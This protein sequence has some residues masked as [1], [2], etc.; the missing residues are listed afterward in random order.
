M[1]N[2]LILLRRSRMSN[3]G[4]IARGKHKT[5]GGCLHIKRLTDIDE[6]VLATLIRDAFE[7]TRSSTS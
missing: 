4:L 3:S 7:H 6:K 2:R 1:L 5:S